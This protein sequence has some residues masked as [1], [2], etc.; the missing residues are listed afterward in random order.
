MRLVNLVMLVAA[1]LG[2]GVSN[3]QAADVTIE[4][5]H[6]CCGACVKAVNETLKGVK[7]VSDVTAEQKAGT[8]KFKAADQ[9]AVDEAIKGLAKEGFHGSATADGK[10]VKFP[11]SGAK[12]G[13]K[14]NSITVTDVHLC[15]GQCER[16]ADKALEGLAGMKEKKIDKD[17]K[18]ITVTGSDIEIAAFVDALNKAGF[19]AN[20]KK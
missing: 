5:V 18:T 7:G 20:L 10:E 15:C 17:A 12:K 19:H 2:F 13:E 4:K 6:L 11:D 1:V 3:V 14:A 16:L 9:A 8:V